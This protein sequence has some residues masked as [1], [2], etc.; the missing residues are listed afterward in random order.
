MCVLLAA[1]AS[2]Q[3]DNERLAR[4]QV[5]AETYTNVTV[6]SV[7]ATEIFFSHSRGFCN[8]KLKDLDPESQRIFHFD[9]P[10]AA[11]LER[12]QAQAN[13]L[14]LREIQKQPAHVPAAPEE[15]QISVEV[16]EPTVEY[17][18]W[19]LSGEKPP[20]ITG[21]RQLGNTRSLFEFRSDFT[22]EPTRGTNG[23]LFTFHVVSAKLCLALPTTITL[24]IGGS[25]KL[26]DH[27]EDHRKIN[28]HFYALGRRGAEHAGQLVLGREFESSAIDL[29]SAQADVLAR[30]STIAKADY[31][32]YTRWP[33]GVANNYYDEVTEHGVK[34]TDADQ[35]FRDAIDRAQVL[36]P[37]G[38]RLA[39]D[40]GAAGGDRQR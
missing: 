40:S 17:K 20:E 28:E 34:N 30:A 37:K 3:A 25:A 35:V 33:A 18:Y 7:S 24:P 31:W 14:F 4:L 9:R 36:V 5:G 2:V 32:K 12:Q 29:E 22:L 1:A 26:K 38:D 27:E 23:G 39:Q 8:S 19:S 6:T 13:A 16:A 11:E 21:E 15:P 10:K